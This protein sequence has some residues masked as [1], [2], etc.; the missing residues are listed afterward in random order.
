MTYA[1]I[2][3]T[4]MIGQNDDPAEVFTEADAHTL[5]SFAQQNH[6][7]RLAFWSVDRDQACG[8]SVSGLPACSDWPVL[9]AE[10]SPTLPTATW[11]F[12]IEG[13][14]E[15]PVTWSWEEI[16]ALPS[17]AY[18]G[19]IHCVTT[20][21]KLGVT[22][23]GVSVDT[24]LEAAR[25][26]CSS[27]TSTSGRAPSGCPA[28]A[29]ST[30]TSR[31]SGSRT[32]TTT[33]ATPGANSATRVTDQPGGGLATSGPAP[34]PRPGKWQ[35]ARVTEIRPETPTAKTFRLA[36]TEPSPYPAGQ[37]YV[38]RLTA[39]D[40]YT[41]Q[42]SYSVASAPD[43]SGAIELTVER[44]PDGEVSSF[45]HDVVMVGDELEVRGPIGDYA[46]ELPG[47][48]TTIAYTRREPGRGRAATPRP[49][50]RRPARTAG[51]GGRCG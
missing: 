49:T 2:G 11:N 29:S 12:G 13:L 39:P 40:G 16:T 32:A 43:G 33:G 38:V 41:A 23:H 26:G 14:V 47:P 9:T 35:P 30:T 25:P 20:W 1:N 21:S 31:A 28:S 5:V 7:G 4:P 36:L 45:L 34:F 24:L 18:N 46:S 15:K 27:R 8:G 51:T 3:V 22:F 48:E 17:S 42:R 19:D 44:L 10:A 50:P 37:H 6:L